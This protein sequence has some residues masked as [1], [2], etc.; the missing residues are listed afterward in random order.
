M[1]IGLHGLHGVGKDTAADYLVQKYG[2]VRV[3]FADAIYT[4]VADAFGVTEA[5]L[6][7]R[8]WKNNVQPGLELRKC[9]DRKFVQLIAEREMSRIVAPHRAYRSEIVSC[10]RSS[11]FIIQHWATEYRRAEFGVNYWANQVEYQ[12][13]QLMPF[14]SIVISDV[15][16]LHEVEMIERFTAVH[17]PLKCGIA[18]IEMQGA[19]RTDHS[20]DNGLPPEY[21]DSIIT[22][23]PGDITLLYNQIETFIQ[24][25]LK[26]KPSKKHSALRA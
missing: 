23:T 6:R 5:Q 19:F 25:G 26:W 15:R 8:E 4:Q 16:E 12:M 10:P 7:S 14:S 22:N 2:F 21:I 1:I 11:T 13:R 20:S 17:G 18:Q 3:A 24:T 9:K